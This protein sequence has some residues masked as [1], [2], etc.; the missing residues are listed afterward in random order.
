MSGHLKDDW[1]NKIKD[2]QDIV[3]GSGL[4]KGLDTIDGMSKKGE[5]KERMVNQAEAMRAVFDE[6]ADID[7]RFQ[8]HKPDKNKVRQHEIVRYECLRCARSIM[9]LCP[10]SRE[11]AI[12]VRKMEEA[13]MWSN[14]AIS[15][16][17]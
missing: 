8:Y 10:D 9:A 17:G 5:I 2:V 15:R 3:E 6:Y 7:W 12:A 11:R 13:M 1:S 16:R 4:T 14:A